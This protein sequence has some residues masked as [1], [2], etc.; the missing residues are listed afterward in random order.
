[1]N[2]FLYF[3]I[4]LFIYIL[5]FDC[6]FTPTNIY[7]TSVDSVHVVLVDDNGSILLVRGKSNQKWQLPG[8]LIDPGETA[9]EAALREFK[10]ETGFE[11]TN[12]PINAQFQKISK[13]GYT[14]QYKTNIN[15]KELLDYYYPP[16]DNLYWDPIN[17]Q[18][19]DIKKNEH[20]AISFFYL[21]KFNKY[22]VYN[23][24][25]KQNKTNKREGLYNSLKILS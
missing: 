17:A 8:G 2:L 20:D 12:H 19:Y 16:K 1:M 11:L 6:N 10:E 21:N 3:L 24:Q 15:F 5:L 18:Y 13:D 4:L 7:Q 14:H 9:D 22:I 25:Q 23:T